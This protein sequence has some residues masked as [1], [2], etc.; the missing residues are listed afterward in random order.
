[1]T[2]FMRGRGNI[3]RWLVIMADHQPVG[4][5]CVNP[6]SM[7]EMIDAIADEA[8]RTESSQR[9]L[10]IAGMRFNPYLPAIRRVVVLDAVYSLLKAIKDRPRDVVRWIERGAGR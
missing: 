5:V 2:G 3:R 10:L 7:D 1:M 6:K 8:S 4:L 9:A